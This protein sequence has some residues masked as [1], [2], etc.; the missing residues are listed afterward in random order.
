LENTN[1]FLVERSRF[2]YWRGAGLASI[3]LFSGGEALYDIG[4]GAFRVNGES[5]LLL[6]DGQEY[7]IS[8]DSPTP[9]ESFCVFFADG[10]AE[11]VSR[12]LLGSADSLLDEP[13]KSDARSKAFFQR[14]YPHD[15]ILSPA[16]QHIREVYPLRKDEPGWLEEQFHRLMARLLVRHEHTYREVEAFPAMR[17]ATRE[18]LYRRLYLARDTILA[19]YDQPLTLEAIARTACLSPNHL[20]RTFKAAF[21]QTP[22]QFLTDV[23]LRQAARLLRTTDAPVTDIC[24]QVGYESLG[25]FSWLFSRRFGLSP[26]AYR[27]QKR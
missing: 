19:L 15:L 3:K 22:Y 13:D 12:S 27:A 24:M 5:Y 23:R 9:V 16:L 4:G 21:G 6:N 18:E 20:L 8:I 10:F 11:A 25:S 26:A 1:F 7:T 17:A 14:T 2:H